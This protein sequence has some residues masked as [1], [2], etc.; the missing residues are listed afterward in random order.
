MAMIMQKKRLISGIPESKYLCFG[1]AG[2]TQRAA[3]CD[4][5]ANSDEYFEQCAFADAVVA[6]YADDFAWL[7][8]EVDII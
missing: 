5:N 1:A 3:P 4:V 7:D 6:D 8:A 2:T